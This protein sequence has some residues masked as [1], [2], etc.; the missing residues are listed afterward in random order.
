MRLFLDGAY[1]A[2]VDYAVRQLSTAVG[3]SFQRAGR[4]EADVVAGATGRSPVID[5]LVEQGRLYVP[6]R[7][8]SLALRRDAHQLIVAGRDDQGLMYALLELTDQVSLEGLHPT[9]A[10]ETIDEPA[11]ELRGI[12]TFLHNADCEREWFPSAEHWRDYFDL[13]ARSRY[14]SFQL[15]LAHQTSYL[16]PPFPFFIDVPEHPEVTVPS[17]T[18]DERRRN[19]DALRMI[20]DLAAE[21]GLEFVVGIWEV[22]PWT[23]GAR[24]GHRQP[25]MVEGLGHHNLVPYTYL[26]TRR[27][28]EEVP[29]IKGLQLRVNPESGIPEE[30]Q[31][32]FFTATVFE[33]LRT[34]GRPVL[35]DLRGWG[36][37]AETITAAEALGLPMRLSMKFWAEHLG[38][39]YQAAEQDPAYSYADFLRHPRHAPV[40]YQVWA[41]GSH[42]HFVWGNPDYVRTFAR[43]LGFGDAV[44]FEISP[45]LAQ[46][47]FGNEP[48]AW[49]VLAPEHEYYRWE[50]ERYWLF[51]LLFGRLTYDP[52]ASQVSWQRHLTS[53]FGPLAHDVLEAYRAGSEV[54]SFLILVAMSDPN[55]YIWPEADTGGLLDHYSSVTPS[56]TAF[57]KSFRESAAE[58]MTGSSTARLGPTDASDHLRQ[59]GEQCRHVVDRLRT[60]ATGQDI[61]RRD[62]LMSTIVDV[63]ALGELALYHAA[64]DP[65]RRAGGHL[66]GER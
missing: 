49:R 47:G 36:A 23:P 40:S 46:K 52:G 29:G 25:S 10:R 5:R 22:L 60:R 30:G 19:R 57:V 13:L 45:P 37:S 54:L 6:G 21:H 14:N 1:H 18:D 62:E 55:M 39:P 24:G 66:R 7:P 35:L 61:P 59:I 53:R 12:F 31:T 43:S 3:E 27:L 51:Y 16:A 42:R 48:G 26:A 44:G 64:E 50:W 28:L 20:A 33:A 34:C 32:E 58:R 2:K 38:P 41:L 9:A 63:Q 11:T 65:G 8:E 4:D 15:V 56:D 17:L